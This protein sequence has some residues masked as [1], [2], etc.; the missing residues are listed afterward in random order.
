MRRFVN[1]FQHIIQFVLGNF[2]LYDF[3]L[4]EIYGLT[5]DYNIFLKK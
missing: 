2:Q 1:R 5:V 3:L 4:Y